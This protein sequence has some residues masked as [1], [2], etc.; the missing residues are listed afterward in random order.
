MRARNILR[1]QGTILALVL[2]TVCAS[3]ARADETI[4]LTP[5]V[6]K[7]LRF[8]R[9]VGTVAIGDP[10]V[11][12]A[13]APN[14]KAIL[15]TGK[16]VGT[17]NVIFLDGEGRDLLSADVVVAR[18]EEVAQ[19]IT[20]HSRP[21]LHSY[22]EYRCAPNCVLIGSIDPPRTAP[23]MPVGSAVPTPHELTAPPAEITTAPAE[24]TALPTERAAPQPAR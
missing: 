12:D 18:G 11:A 3:G 19:R 17:T 16:A 23:T 21:L 15:L 20:I 2:L 1:S 22:D 9:P 10:Q 4:K 14:D 5:G 7:L 24:T 6:V 13:F 8:D